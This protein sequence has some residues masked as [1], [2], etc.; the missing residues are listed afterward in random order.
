MH[1]HWGRL[2]STLGAAALALLAA[3]ATAAQA[4]PADDPVDVE[5]RQDLGT[6]FTAPGHKLGIRPIAEAVS[7]QVKHLAVTL[8]LPEGVTYQGTGDDGASADCTPAADG[9]SVTCADKDGS[10][11][12][13]SADV[14]VQVG[15]DVAPGTVLTFTTTADIGDAVDAKPANNTATGKLEIRQPAD[16]SFAWKQPKVSVKPGE[17]VKTEAVVTN[18]GPGPVKLEAVEFQTGWDYGPEDGSYDKGCWWDPGVL[19]CDVFRELAPGESVTFPFAWN[20][21]QKAAGTTYRVPAFLYQSSLLDE[22][23]A[24]DKETLVFTIAKASTPTK[25][26]TPKPTATPTVK[27]TAT[28]TPA[29]ASSTTAPAPGSDV[30]AQGGSGQLAATGTG[31][32]TTVGATAAALTV[33]GGA[34][35][36]TR[37]TRRREH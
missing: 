4:A 12:S 14:I 10:T 25:R 16:L 24:N 26:P 30:T 32:L 1:R 29:P 3:S 27:P 21:P 22:N 13:V 19:I 31:P 33:A 5:A 7:G 35:A 36:L 6:P 18:H 17:D 34:L 9:R 8:T 20:F 11:R 2:T 37:R 28:A 23:P 15:R